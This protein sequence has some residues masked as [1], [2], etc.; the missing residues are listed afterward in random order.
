MGHW[1]RL[2]MGLTPSPFL[3]A[4]TLLW[5]EE[6][7]C[8]ECQAKDNS[9]HWEVIVQIVPGSEHYN[10]GV[11]CVRK[12]GSLLNYLGQQDTAQKIR[13]PMTGQPGAWAG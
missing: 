2:I 5:G 13:P 11:A 7:I 10:P 3:S 1:A 9:L 6:I 4:Q 12:V 8:G